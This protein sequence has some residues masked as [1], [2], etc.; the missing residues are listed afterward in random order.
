MGC[1]RKICQ[2]ILDQ[3]ADCR[4]AL[5]NNQGRLREDVDPFSYEHP[6]RGTGTG[7]LTKS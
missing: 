7:F 6:E 3:E 2:Q 4:I 1:Q 5:R